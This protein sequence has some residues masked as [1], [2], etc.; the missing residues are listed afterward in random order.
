M[1]ARGRALGTL[2]GSSEIK[3]AGE[4]R[5]KETVEP[6]SPSDSCTDARTCEKRGGIYCIYFSGV[7][8]SEA[9]NRNYVNRAA[10]GKSGQHGFSNLL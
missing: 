6:G 9:V 1:G 3:G 8:C 2:N 7:G 4:L 10:L 5:E